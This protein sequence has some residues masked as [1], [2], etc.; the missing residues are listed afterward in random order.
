MPTDPYT[1]QFN[2]RLFN[3][4]FVHRPDVEDNLSLVLGETHKIYLSTTDTLTTSITEI[5][6]G[7]YEPNLTDNLSVSSQELSL[8]TGTTPLIDTVNLSLDET[9]SITS[10]Q[11]IEDDLHVDIFDTAA[12]HE[13]LYHEDHYNLISDT[14][15][16]Y[17]V[18]TSDGT[19]LSDWS[20]TL[21][22]HYLIG[23]ED[24]ISNDSLIINSLEQ[25]TDRVLDLQEPATLNV[26]DTAVMHI[27]ASDQI[28]CQVDDVI[29]QRNFTTSDILSTKIIDISSIYAIAPSASDV[30]AIQI[31]NVVYQRTFNQQDLSVIQVID[32]TLTSLNTTTRVDTLSLL[33]SDPST[34]QGYLTNQ[35]L[36]AIRVDENVFLPGVLS[37]TDTLHI[38]TIEAI[39]DRTYHNTEALDIQLDTSHLIT[40]DIADITTLNVIEDSQLTRPLATEDSLDVVLVGTSIY[41]HLD[42]HDA[43]TL[44][45]IDDVLLLTILD[46]ALP[47][48]EH[49]TLGWSVLSE[50]TLGKSKL[51]YVLI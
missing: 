10:T 44:N 6:H 2:T 20:N 13:P 24:R 16:Y 27:Y 19:T 43:V 4:A 51:N 41:I 32:T 1:H 45:I 33:I 47:T 30:C 8:Q 21:Q 31:D 29:I 25:V 23:L 42:T 15:Y 28:G 14:I 34:M 5:Y 40:Q 12:A 7:Q 37:L 46:D 39:T 36:I 49:S 11:A 38:N 17:E 9:F 50:S 3:E 26:A 48:L 35:D 18:C 22:V